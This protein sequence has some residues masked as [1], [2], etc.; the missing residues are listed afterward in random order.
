MTKQLFI[1]S[2]KKSE[3]ANPSSTRNMSKIPQKKGW[4]LVYKPYGEQG[5]GYYYQKI[6]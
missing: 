5:R 3:H 2:L 6:D 4:R 1:R